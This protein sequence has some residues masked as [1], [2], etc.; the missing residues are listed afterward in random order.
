VTFTK[1][2]TIYLKV[3]LETILLDN[4]KVAIVWFSSTPQKPRAKGLVPILELLG[5]DRDFKRWYLLQGL[6]ITGTYL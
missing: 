1:V 4:N 3:T 2:F 6:Q 5:N